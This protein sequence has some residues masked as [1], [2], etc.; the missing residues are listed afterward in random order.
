MRQSGGCSPKTV[1]GEQATEQSN[2]HPGLHPEGMSSEED[3]AYPSR[4]REPYSRL[5][6]QG[7][8]PPVWVVWEK[9]LRRAKGLHTT[10][11]SR[12]F[13]RL[14][15]EEKATHVHAPIDDPENPV[16][17]SRPLALAPATVR[18]RL[19]S[20]LVSGDILSILTVP[21]KDVVISS[22]RTKSLTEKKFACHVRSEGIDS[23]SESDVPR[24]GVLVHAQTPPQSPKIRT[25]GFPDR[26]RR[27]RLA[28][29]QHLPLANARFSFAGNVI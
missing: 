14:R 16:C 6:I 21:D 10:S 3:W 7:A 19:A 26:R 5:L 1:V 4:H 28:S 22:I 24:C 9:G 17:H 18:A 29:A 15:E 11:P 25:R 20:L 2:L 8:D 13:Y 27:R 12:Y 23:R